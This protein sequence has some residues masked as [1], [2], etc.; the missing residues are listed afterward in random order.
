MKTLITNEKSVV[1]DHLFLILVIVATVIPNFSFIT[2]Y[3][4]WLITVGI[5]SICSSFFIKKS[6]SLLDVSF[7]CLAMYLSIRFFYFSTSFN[8]FTSQRFLELLGY[9]I[10]YYNIS[11]AFKIKSQYLLWI[12][13]AIISVCVVQ[14]FIGLLQ[15]QSILPS[16][17]EYFVLTGT[18]TSPNYL[19]L[20]LSIGAVLLSWY[21]LCFETKNKKK[22]I[23]ALFV[24]CFLMLPI[25]LSKS[26]TSWLVLLTGFSYL[27]VSSGVLKKLFNVISKKIALLIAMV[28]TAIIAYGIINLYSFKKD[29][30]DGRLLI[31]KI[32]SQE[33][34]KKPFLGHGLFSF[35]GG[36]N[37]AKT[38][39]FNETKRPWSEVKLGNYAFDTFNDYLYLA[40]ELGFVGLFIVLFI[41]GYAIYFGGSDIYAKLGIALLL[42]L[43][44]AAFFMPIIKIPL[45][46]ILGIIGIQLCVPTSKHS[47]VIPIFFQK[48]SQLLIFGTSVFLL[49]VVFKDVRHSKKLNAFYNLSD[50]KKREVSETELQKIYGDFFKKGYATFNQGYYLYNLGNYDQGLKAMEK[51]YVFNKAPKLGRHLGYIYLNTQNFERASALFKENIGNEPFRYEPRMDLLKV[52]EATGNEKQII[53]LCKEIIALPVKIPSKEVKDYKKHCKQL[54]QY[55]TGDSYYDLEEE[56]YQGLHNEQLLKLDK[57]TISS[58]LKGNISEELLVESNIL[59][60]TLKHRIYLPNINYITKSL[61]VVYLA[62]GQQYVKDKSFVKTI[63]KLILNKKITP[64]ALV[65]MDSSDYQ[66]PSIDHRQEYYLCNKKYVDFVTTELIPE[67]EKYYPVSKERTERSIMGYSFG[68]LFAAFAGMEAPDYFKNVIMQSPAYHP[69]PDIYTDY[70]TKETLDLNMYLSYGTGKDTESQDVPMIN[71]LQAKNYRLKVNREEGANHEWHVWMNQTKDIFKHYFKID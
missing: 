55:Y 60:R 2:N 49:V 12:V 15:Y 61:P 62:D 22:R 13:F 44:I 16:K 29:S 53:Q 46:I 67:I 63:D 51:G 43:V 3:Y 66:D 26:R 27:L 34:L 69:C 6:F 54:L 33:I 57:Q 56:P 50:D 64:V 17:N 20:F 25:I 4:S 19:G 1:L 65:F 7:G 36:Y 10:V 8:G 23:I 42:C 35:E 39:Y 45:F 48:I 41:I 71:I 5:W 68:G 59:N 37:S 11:K 18:F 40:Y 32:T 9:I 58:Q 31:A 14:A 70:N 52:Y 38:T 28:F 24:F 30:A 47:L 21:L